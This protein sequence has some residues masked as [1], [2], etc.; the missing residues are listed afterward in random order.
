MKR[1]TVHIDGAC[2]PNPGEMGIGVWSKVFRI[3][4]RQ[5][6]GTNNRAEYLALI[7]ALRELRK[8]KTA[9]RVLS[10]SKL[11]V[12]QV[13]RRWRVYDPKIQKLLNKVAKLLSPR[14]SL[15][16]IPREKNLADE[17][18]KKALE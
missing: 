2:Q 17:F 6:Y 1:L 13:N 7:A 10:D 12:E 15:S 4:E 8:R 3:S 9:G 14:D 5:G 16:W 18:A 11:L